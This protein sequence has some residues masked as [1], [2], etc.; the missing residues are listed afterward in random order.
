MRDDPFRVLVTA[1][2]TGGRLVVMTLDEIPG[3]ELPLHIHQHED[4]FIY[5][6]SGNLTVVVDQERYGAAPGSSFLLPR[7]SEH[8]YVVTSA[9]A[10]LLVAIFPAG[11][12]TFLQTACATGSGREIERLIAQA[13]HYGLDIT[14]ELAEGTET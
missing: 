10:K 8:G 5:V 11:L 4:E 3:S 12:E 14:S 13:A 9:K 1:A 6:L 7:G 2:E